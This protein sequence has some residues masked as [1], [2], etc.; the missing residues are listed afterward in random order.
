MSVVTDEDILK[1]AY[2]QHVKELYFYNATRIFSFSTSLKVKS[3]SINLNV[4]VR[5]R[6]MDLRLTEAC[7]YC[8]PRMSPKRN[9]YFR[10]HK[11][12]S[13]IRISNDRLWNEI[14]W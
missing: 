4:T 5:L 6:F 8:H 10:S 9:R 2:C 11:S 13:L 12:G 3:T 14:F 1:T 7:F